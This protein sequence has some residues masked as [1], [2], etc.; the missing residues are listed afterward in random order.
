MSKKLL[1]LGRILGGLAVLIYT[2]GLILVVIGSIFE[3]GPPDT[4]SGDFLEVLPMVIMIPLQLIFYILTWF[5][6]I[7]GELIGGISISIISLCM[8]GYVFY[9][10]GG[11]KLIM[12][13]VFCIPFL[14]PGIIFIIY[15][16]M[17][18]KEE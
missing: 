7:K 12:G 17:K 16:Q 2:G 4:N 13:L 11:M 9:T 18:E 1:L 8:G 10:A 14:I 5:P 15:S 3:E 6:K